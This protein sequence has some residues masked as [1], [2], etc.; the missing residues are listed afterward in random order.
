MSEIAIMKDLQHPHV[1]KLYEVIEDEEGGKVDPLCLSRHAK[2]PSSMLK[3]TAGL[4]GRVDDT[5]L[6]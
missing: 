1:V 5:P 4:R 3:L 2:P 6:N